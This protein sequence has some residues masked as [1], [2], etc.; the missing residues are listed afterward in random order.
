MRHD[1]GGEYPS[2]HPSVALVFFEEQDF[3]LKDTLLASVEEF[4]DWLKGELPTQP[5]FSLWN[6]RNPENIPNQNQDRE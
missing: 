5:R 1:E 3:E 2:K 6:A 4:F